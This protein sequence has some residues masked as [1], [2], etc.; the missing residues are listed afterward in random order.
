MFNWIGLVKSLSGL[1]LSGNPLVF[2]PAH[3]VESGTQVRPGL[4]DCIRSSIYKNN[5]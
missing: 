1:N 3:V 2:P 4:Q 5:K